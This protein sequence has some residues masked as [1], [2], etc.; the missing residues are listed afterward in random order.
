LAVNPTGQPSVEST[1]VPTVRP[2]VRSVLK[3]CKCA[4]TKTTGYYWKD[5]MKLAARCP[6]SRCWPCCLFLI[7]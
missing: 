1:V 5:S 6:V 4:I 2:A 7:C 3:L